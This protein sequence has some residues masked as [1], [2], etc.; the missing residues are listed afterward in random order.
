MQVIFTLTKQHC[1][2]RKH[3]S[4]WATI[5][6]KWNVTS[7]IKRKKKNCIWDAAA[8]SVRETRTCSWSQIRKTSLLT[9]FFFICLKIFFLKGSVLGGVVPTNFIWAHLYTRVLEP[10]RCEGLDS[11]L[12]QILHIMRG[13]GEF[14]GILTSPWLAECCSH[15]ICT[16]AWERHLCV[17]ESQRARLWMARRFWMG[18]WIMYWKRGH[19]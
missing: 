10:N 11:I 15:G 12:I 16:G 13:T 2:C 18:S 7:L 19:L 6:V 9:A 5:P 3:E 14:V 4:Y 17:T 8:S 1:D